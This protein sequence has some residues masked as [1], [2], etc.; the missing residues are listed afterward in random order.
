L[1]IFVTPV[2]AFLLSVYFYWA[3]FMDYAV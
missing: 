2:L 3:T 1:G